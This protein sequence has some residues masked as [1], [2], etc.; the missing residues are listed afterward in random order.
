MVHELYELPEVR[1]EM[2]TRFGDGVAPDGVIDRAA[3]ARAAFA[4]PAE[5]QWLESF[6]WPRVGAKMVSWRSAL[7]RAAAPPRAAVV[8]VPLLF[9]SGLEGAF[10]ATIAIVA[11]ESLR[12]ERAGA[13]GHEALGERAS[14]QLTQ[15]EKADR[16]TY[17]VANDGSVAELEAKL[18]DV[19]AMLDRSRP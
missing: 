11:E 18:S 6:L 17:V 15:A 14:R 5:R 3:I 10:D 12:A 9:E 2:V 7:D 4:D 13:R 16:A 8:E 1:D 19:L